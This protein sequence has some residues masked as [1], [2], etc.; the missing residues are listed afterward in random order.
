MTKLDIT[1]PLSDDLIDQIVDGLLA[2][3]ATPRTPSTFSTA[4]PT[5]GNGAL[6]RFSKPSAGASRF[7]WSVSRNQRVSRPKSRRSHQATSIR[8]E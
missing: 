5:D 4:I 2:P 8:A 7:A 3:A 6:W 1:N